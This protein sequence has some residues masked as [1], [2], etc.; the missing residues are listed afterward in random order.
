MK[1]DHTLTAERLR[2]LVEYRDGSLYWRNPKPKMT[3]GPL[4]SRAG[5]AGRLQVHIGGVA[6]YVHR[7]I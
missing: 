6:R 4:G 7:L 1:T 2:E 3:L 5:H